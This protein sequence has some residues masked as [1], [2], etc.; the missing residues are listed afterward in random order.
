MYKTVTVEYP[1][2][3]VSLPVELSIVSSGGIDY[4]AL[5]GAICMEYWNGSVPSSTQDGFTRQ[6]PL[7][8]VIV[9]YWAAGYLIWK[10]N[11]VL[12]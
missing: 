4:P 11:T 8:G 9:W 10:S 7:N 3:S 12:T 1:P 5:E 2:A 6:I